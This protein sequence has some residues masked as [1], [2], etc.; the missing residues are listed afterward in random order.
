[1]ITLN[2]ILLLLIFLAFPHG[3][4]DHR[5]MLQFVLTAPPQDHEPSI[6]S[7]ISLPICEPLSISPTSYRNS[8]MGS[9]PFISFHDIHASPGA[10]I[11]HWGTR[12]CILYIFPPF[13][14]Y[15]VVQT[16]FITNL[17]FCRHRWRPVFLFWPHAT[18][19]PLVGVSLLIYPHRH[20]LCLQSTTQVFYH[21]SSEFTYLVPPLAQLT[22][23]LVVPMTLDLVPMVAATPSIM[24]PPTKGS[25]E[26][27]HFLTS[28]MY[29]CHFITSVDSTEYLFAPKSRV[30]FLSTSAYFSKRATV[31]WSSFPI[32]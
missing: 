32:Q 19:V 9:P 13:I 22:S 11:K 15:F 1:M 18:H 23:D 25:L 24:H 16:P 21:L 29:L 26:S 2:H 14:Y 12:F 30:T 10:F 8:P 28:P 20:H 27:S 6:S 31:S 7:T 3:L 5:F 4:P 17:C